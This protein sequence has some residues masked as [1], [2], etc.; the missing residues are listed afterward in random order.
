[1]DFGLRILDFDSGSELNRS[2]DPPNSRTLDFD[3]GSE[4]LQSK[5]RDRKSKIPVQEMGAT[6]ENLTDGDWIADL[7][8]S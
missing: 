2:N 1:L 3:S 4:L 8:S 5:I 6:A 7:G